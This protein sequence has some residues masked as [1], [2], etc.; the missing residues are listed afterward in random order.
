MSDI[1]INFRTC[2]LE[3]LEKDY[4]DKFVILPTDNTDFGFWGELIKKNFDAKI[5]ED[6][7]NTV[8]EHLQEVGS[9]SSHDARAF[10]D[11]KGGRVLVDDLDKENLLNPKT[12]KAGLIKFLNADEI[13]ARFD[14]VNR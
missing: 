11:S 13:K 14:K 10:L 12:F 4:G 9:L 1:I 3:A 5:V 8:S 7:W 2:V 6:L